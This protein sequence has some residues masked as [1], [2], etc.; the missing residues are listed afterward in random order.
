MRTVWTIVKKELSRFFKDKRML[1]A[2]FLPGILI[3]ALYSLL[4][5]VMES[6]FESEENQTYRVCVVN[7]PEWLTE[8]ALASYGVFELQTASAVDENVEEKIKDGTFNA[9]LVFPN[10]FNLENNGSVLQEVKLYLDS[11]DTLSQSAGQ[12]LMGAL[13]SVQYGAPKFLLTPQDVASEAELS[14]MIFSMIGPMLILVM[15][16]TGCIAVAPESIAGEKER[17]TLAT[18]LVTPVKRS[19]IAVGKLLALSI[20]SVLSGLSSFIGIVLSLPK[21]M[22]GTGVEISALTYGAGEYLALLG[23]VLSSV[24]VMVGVVSIASTFA[25]SVKEASGMVSPIMILA[26]VAGM[27]A[28]F[29]PTSAW[30]VYCIPLINSAAAM[31]GIFSLA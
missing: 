20:I 29:L 5:G 17:G 1:V 3:Y 16:M 21:L 25:K 11:T 6:M 30:Y 27:T 14:S 9:Y 22:S 10:S 2:L 24:L 31:N 28:S 18:M 23:I 26:L 7:C 4:G 12:A 19:R 15:L 13:S 8:E